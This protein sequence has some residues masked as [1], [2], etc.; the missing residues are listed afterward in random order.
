[1]DERYGAE[2]GALLRRWLADARA[3][4][5]LGDMPLSPAPNG[6]GEKAVVELGAGLRIFVKAN[7]RKPPKLV[8]GKIDW[9]SVARILIQRIVKGND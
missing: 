5:C 3:A 4:G 9:S 1:M 2:G 7:H 8:G 6:S